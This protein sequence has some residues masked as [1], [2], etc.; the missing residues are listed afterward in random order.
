M[1]LNLSEERSLWHRVLLC[2]ILILTFPLFIV[3]TALCLGVY[4]AIIQV[5]SFLCS[6]SYTI[7]KINFVINCFEQSQG[8]KLNIFRRGTKNSES[9]IIFAFSVL[10]GDKNFPQT[11]SSHII[12]EYFF[13]DLRL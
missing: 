6:I 10:L 2:P 3:G 4:A 12:S 11:F 13:V 8:Q 9:P 7:I 1:Y 5:C